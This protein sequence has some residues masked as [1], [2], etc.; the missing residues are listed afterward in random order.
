MPLGRAD[1][2]AAPEQI[3]PGQSPVSVEQLEKEAENSAEDRTAP[4]GT[5]GCVCEVGG[6]WAE[7]GAEWKST[8]A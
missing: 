6:D 5:D 1:F 2:D 3:G 7:E 8:V 4:D